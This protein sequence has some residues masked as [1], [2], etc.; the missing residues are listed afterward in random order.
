MI[1]TSLWQHLSSPLKLNLPK[2]FSIV[3]LPKLPAHNLQSCLREQEKRKQPS[4]GVL[5]GSQPRASNCSR[6]SMASQNSPNHS[7]SIKSS[8]T[9]QALSMRQKT[10]PTTVSKRPQS[11]LLNITCKIRS[12]KTWA[13]SWVSGKPPLPA[14]TS[15]AWDSPQLPW[16]CASPRIITKTKSSSTDRVP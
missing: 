10:E 14:P 3:E 16:G 5:S 7:S 15:G 2:A 8:K 9:F 12:C 11:A 13:P 1:Q 6:T 4:L